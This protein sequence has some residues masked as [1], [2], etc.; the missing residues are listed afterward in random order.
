[1]GFPGAEA[2]KPDLLSEQENNNADEDLAA[3]PVQT[4]SSESSNFGEDEENEEAG[5]SIV[6]V[7]T[8]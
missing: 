5:S 4:E 7:I 3:Q 2:E 8:D 6:P 1:M